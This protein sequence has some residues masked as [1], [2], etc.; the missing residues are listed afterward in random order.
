VK[1]GNI[2]A[3]LSKIRPAVEKAEYSGERN[4]KNEEFVHKVCE[5]NVKH[6]IEQIRAKSAIL[7]EM[8]NKGEIK[9]IGGIYD[10]DSGKVSFLE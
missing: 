9:I 3:M 7:K 5:S 4:S 2:T 10:L 8:E 6:T 1:L